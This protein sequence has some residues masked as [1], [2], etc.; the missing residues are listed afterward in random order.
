M[1]FLGRL[2]GKRGTARSTEGDLIGQVGSLLRKQGLVSLS[3]DHS[4]VDKALILDSMSEYFNATKFLRMAKAER[5]GSVSTEDAMIDEWRIPGPRGKTVFFG[6][7]T[8][9]EEDLMGEL[10]KSMDM[11]K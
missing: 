11:L 9:S 10:E 7:R 4:S 2:F 6:Y 5:V 8:G 3:G 1:G